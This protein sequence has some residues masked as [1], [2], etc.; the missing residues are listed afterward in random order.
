[1]K[2]IYFSGIVFFLK[3]VKMI[4]RIGIVA[5]EIWSYLDNHGKEALIED[6]IVSLKRDRDIVLM[7]MGWL[8]REGH[9]SVN[10]EQ[11]NY[12]IKLT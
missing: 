8:A 11:K 1:M 6:I 7:S 10:S 12:K 5:G 3:G 9:I 2:V 4:T